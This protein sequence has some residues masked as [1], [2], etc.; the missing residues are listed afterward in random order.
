MAIVSA[1]RYQ[2]VSRY[3]NVIHSKFC[4]QHTAKPQHTAK[5]SNNSLTIRI[6]DFL[7]FINNSKIL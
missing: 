3:N 5:I 2:I 4:A 1:Y 7:K 6:W